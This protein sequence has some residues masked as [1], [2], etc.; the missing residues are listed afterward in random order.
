LTDKCFVEYKTDPRKQVYIHYRLLKGNASEDYIT[1]RM[2]NIFMGIHAK[3]FVLFYHEILQY[4]ITEEIGEE[5]TI[6]ESFHLNFDQEIAEDEESKFNQIN[7]ML[8]AI[9]M[10][11]EMT[12]LDIMEHYVETQYMISKCFQPME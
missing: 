4:Y 10:Q 8:M 2:S 7:L 12:L 1:E 3:E 9:E 5:V 6:T 11:D